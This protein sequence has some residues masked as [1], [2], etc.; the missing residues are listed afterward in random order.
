MEI[1]DKIVLVGMPGCGKSTLGKLLAEKLNYNFYDMD[2]YIEK[3]SESTIKD[4][5]SKGEENFRKW[6]TKA[7]EE[8]SLKKRAVISSG[9]GVVTKS[10]NID[11]LNKDCIILFINRPI[12]QII[13]DLETENRPLLKDN[14]SRIYDLYNQRINLYKK[15]AHIEI[16]NSGIINE[17]IKI[18]INEL[19][20]KIK[21]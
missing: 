15:A 5:F 14:T 4:L 8:L 10:R 7:C 18:I 2:D 1:K 13:S 20:D 16:N 17:T 3:I 9:G 19:K 21:E 11:I 12:E 6:E